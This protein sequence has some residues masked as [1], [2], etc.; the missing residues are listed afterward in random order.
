MS[1]K[2]HFSSNS[3]GY[4]QY[5]PVYPEELFEYL[6]TLIEDHSLAWDCA[7]G[8]GQAAVALAPYFEQVI[9]TDASP[10]QLEKS[11][12]C[13]NVEY[14][15]ANAEHTQIKAESVNLI[16]VAQAYHW[17]DFERFLQEVDRVLKPG[18]ILAIWCYQLLRPA[19]NKDIGDRIK[20]FYLNDMVDYWPNERFH[21]DKAYMNLPF[22]GR[23][24]EVPEMTMA[25]SCEREQFLNYL[26][27][28][29]AVKNYQEKHGVN[30]V[31]HLLRQDFERLWPDGDK[32]KDFT[33]PLCLRIS[34]KI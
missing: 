31:D 5:R 23:E 32:V 7:T 21:I 30:A 20:S 34:R 4:C 19:K 29:S 22:Y 2:D 16:T 14:K 12:P 6:S 17:F 8:N 1:F 3:S 25:M 33:S 18:G 28:W 15:V 27:T 9:A 26:K 24:L 10:Q 11:I 13:D